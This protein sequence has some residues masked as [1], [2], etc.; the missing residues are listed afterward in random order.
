MLKSLKDTFNPYTPISVKAFWL[1]Q[2]WIVWGG[3]LLLIPAFILQEKGVSP[4]IVIN[5]VF[6]AFALMMY[7]ELIFTI[8]RYRAM[9]IPAVWACF[10]CILPLNIIAFTVAAFE[11][12]PAQLKYINKFLNFIKKDNTD[13][14]N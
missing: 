14:F 2:C 7:I 4:N 8:K 5:M 10:V 9:K 6:L 12:S 13:G 1:R 3:F 11:K